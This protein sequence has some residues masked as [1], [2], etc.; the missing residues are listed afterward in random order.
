MQK[1]D[2]IR[3]TIEDLSSDGL[4]VATATAWLFLSRIR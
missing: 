2:L 3:V 1:D 4:G